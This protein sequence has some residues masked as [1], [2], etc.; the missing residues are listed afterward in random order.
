MPFAGAAMLPGSD[1]ARAC[2]FCLL[3]LSAIYAGFVCSVRPHINVVRA[4]M[5]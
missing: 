5:L 4:L 1:A 2:N 3:F